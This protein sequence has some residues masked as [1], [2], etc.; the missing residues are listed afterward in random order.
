MSVQHQSIEALNSLIE[1]NNDRI[2]GY[3]TASKET[4]DAELKTLFSQL[5]GTSMKCNQALIKQVAVLGGTPI[6]GTKTSGKIYR[7]WMD[8]KAML[9]GKDRTSILNSCEY[10]ETVAIE[11]YESVLKDNS[12]NLTSEQQ[13]MLNGQ[14]DYLKADFTK[15]KKLNS[16]LKV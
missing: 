4:E 13:M 10:G 14:L 6:E 12:A 3:N 2:E 8:F 7:I 15:V 9:T 11:H 1:I 16:L 5:S